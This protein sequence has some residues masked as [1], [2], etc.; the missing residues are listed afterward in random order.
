MC[1]LMVVVFYFI[2]LWVDFITYANNHWKKK[3]CGYGLILRFIYLDL[4]DE[5]LDDEYL[6]DEYLDDEHLECT[7]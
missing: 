7:K 3:C 6:D 5:Y 1:L 2:F 4:D